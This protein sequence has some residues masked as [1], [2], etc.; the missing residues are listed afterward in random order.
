MF[1]VHR[2]DGGK[3]AKV[4]GRETDIRMTSS[5][6]GLSESCD[7]T[8]V[9]DG[10]TAEP[11][12]L[13]MGKAAQDIQA[14]SMDAD[15]DADVNMNT[16]PD[17]EIFFEKYLLDDVDFGDAEKMVQDLM[18][19]GLPFHASATQA[20]AVD[21]HTYLHKRIDPTPNIT[22]TLSKELSTHQTPQHITPTRTQ[23]LELTWYSRWELLVELVRRDEMRG[24][25]VVPGPVPGRDKSG[26]RMFYLGA[27]DDCDDEGSG[28]MDVDD[29]EEEDDYGV[30]V[31]NPVYPPSRVFDTG[32]SG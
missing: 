9:E 10:P 19:Q 4:D 6:M 15:V 25:G 8:L 11:A 1:E 30:L 23:P 12:L 21:P 2:M 22:I 7:V 18:P 26:R 16:T 29:D 32:I 24:Q 14:C 20:Q 27:D 28:H 13:E 31:A 17:D 5:S 3:C